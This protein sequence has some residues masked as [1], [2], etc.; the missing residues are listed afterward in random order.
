M[1]PGMSD[2]LI[3]MTATEAVSGCAGARSRR[4]T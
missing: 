4:S 1:S 2:E 3:R